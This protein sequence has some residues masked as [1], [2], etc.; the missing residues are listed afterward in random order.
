[1]YDILIKNGRIVDGF[2]VPSF[3]GDVGIKGERI[4]AI[5]NLG[6]GSEQ[7]KLIDARG[8]VVCPGF[9][10]I[11]SHS[12]FTIMVNPKAESKV[13]QGVTTEVCG[14]CGFSAAPQYQQLK[15]RIKQICQEF[16][17]NYEWNS[18]KE[19]LEIL[20]GIGIGVNFVPLIGQ[21][22][23]RASIVGY[24][25]RRPTLKEVDKMKKL[26]NKCMEEG[27]YGL[28]TGLIYP[29]GCFTQTDELIEI[30][31]VVAEAGGIYVSHL[32][33]EGD[34]LLEAVK[35]AID[36]GGMANVQK[37]HISHLK[38]AGKTN[39]DKLNS[40]FEEIEKTLDLGINITCDRYPYT[41]ASTDLDILLPNWVY[42]GGLEKELER[43]KD[44]NTRRKI[45][46]QILEA[47]HDI[48]FWDSIMISSV[49][50]QANKWMEG[51]RISEI[52]SAKKTLN[53]CEL[54]FSLLIEE[55]RKVEA[56]F[57]NMS[58]D[59]LKKILKKP[60]VM[61]ASDSSARADYGILSTSKPHPRAFGTFPCILA[62]YV[63]EEKVLTLEE[64]IYKMSYQ[65]AQLLGIKN[66]GR[67]KE[68][69]FADV[70]VFNPE[71][72]KDL[73][74]YESP[75]LYPTGIEYVIINGKI[76]IEKG[77]HTDVLTGKVIRKV[78]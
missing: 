13:R 78:S 3:R 44:E 58:E 72:I 55:E 40:V 66:R 49:K 53:P 74:T 57:F 21:G 24:T 10:D 47:Y 69:N 77:N 30:C 63:R 46:Q 61:I 27:A 73:A 64:A 45:L 34:K 7:T 70:V 50:T 71:K 4:I 32:R 76:V 60:Y 14:N 41:A 15:D 51:K 16:E 28:S 37:V 54:V 62:K 22:N 26:I 19:Y 65:P 8:K 42:E 18:L 52:V 9:I 2:N 23:I 31:K 39:W 59:N 20:E 56:N 5:G 35:E 17:I 33:N 25:D 1:M 6:I 29:P 68:G 75:L 36:I 11:H 48:D 67:L 43:L 38:T 12:D